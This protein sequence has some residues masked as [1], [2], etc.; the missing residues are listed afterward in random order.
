[1][2]EIRRIAGDSLP[3]PDDDLV[4]NAVVTKIVDGSWA[5]GLRTRV[6]DRTAERTFIGATCAEVTRATALIVPL[7][8]N[9]NVR[10]DSGPPAPQPP[11]ER[12]TPRPSPVAQPEHPTRTEQARPESK[13]RGPQ[14][15]LGLGALAGL[16]VLPEPRGGFESSAGV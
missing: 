9:P 1:G 7:L 10:V 6:A 4:V 16:G 11:V 15:E 12:P 13:A 2:H 5:V 8:I 3:V 14:V